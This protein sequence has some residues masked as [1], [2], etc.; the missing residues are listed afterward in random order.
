MPKRTK[1]PSRSKPA[2]SRVSNTRVKLYSEGRKKYFTSNRSEHETGKKYSARR[3]G[4][5][6]Q[7]EQ[8]FEKEIAEKFRKFHK[9]H[10]KTSAKKASLYSVS[11]R[12]KF[13]K[14]PSG[15]GLPRAEIRNAAQVEMFLKD[16]KE[17]FIGSMRGYLREK[18][19]S[20][21]NLTGARFEAV[22]FEK[23]KWKGFDWKKQKS[24]LIKQGMKN[25][26]KYQERIS[27]GK[28]LKRVQAK[29]AK[30]RKKSR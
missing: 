1:K 12:Y 26:K 19:R 27:K 22:K 23:K 10:S 30:R 24:N 11:I 21:V 17:E 7:L 16:L 8:F 28:G 9:Y 13:G 15:F 18:G 14:N 2:R 4:S 5:E 20:L 6:R 29:K 25:S 3:G